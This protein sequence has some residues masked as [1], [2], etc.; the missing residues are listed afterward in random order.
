MML[1]SRMQQRGQHAR[2]DAG[3]ASVP[4]CERSRSVLPLRFV[5]RLERRHC[6]AEPY[7]PYP[8]FQRGGGG[9]VTAVVR[10]TRTWMM[11]H[12]QQLHH[13]AAASVWGKCQKRER[14]VVRLVSFP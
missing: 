5:L 4:R 8:R 6:G 10:R 14:A 9:L 13:S 11:R 12:L 1:M 7:R 2:S 3:Q